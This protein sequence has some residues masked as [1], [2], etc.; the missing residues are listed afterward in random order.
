MPL[1][2]ADVK[3]SLLTGLAIALASLFIRAAAR[4]IQEKS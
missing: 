4:E 2:K 3:I 1:N